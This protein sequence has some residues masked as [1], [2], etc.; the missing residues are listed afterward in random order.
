MKIGATTSFASSL[1]PERRPLERRTLVP[2]ILES[3]Q[4]ISAEDWGGMPDMEN[5]TH[6]VQQFQ[7]I[8][9]RNDKKLVFQVLS[10]VLTTLSDDLR[11]L[12]LHNIIAFS[13]IQPM[14]HQK[15]T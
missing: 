5:P 14:I 13:M 1:R 9:N 7:H 3:G 4:W 12:L 15:M 8:V 6:Q 2:I 11:K 10:L